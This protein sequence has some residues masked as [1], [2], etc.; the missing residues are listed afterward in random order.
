MLEVIRIYP[1]RVANQVHKFLREVIII[2]GIVHDS[3]YIMLR[4]KEV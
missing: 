4:V 2:L 1:L 3:F